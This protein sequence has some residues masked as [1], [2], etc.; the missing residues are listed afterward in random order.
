MGWQRPLFWN[1]KPKVGKQW[2]TLQQ[3]PRAL[4]KPSLTYLFPQD[5]KSLPGA[6]CFRVRLPGSWLCLLHGLILWL[7]ATFS[8]SLSPS[9]FFKGFFVRFKWN[10]P[11]KALST[12]YIYYYCFITGITV[13]GR[14]REC[15]THTHTHAHMTLLLDC[16][17]YACSLTWQRGMP[18]LC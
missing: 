8:T 18:I 2:Q 16:K 13:Y 3:A 5:I 6:W 7:W 12:K 9:V 15:F 4:P 11:Y 17:N 1:C 14:E 10:K